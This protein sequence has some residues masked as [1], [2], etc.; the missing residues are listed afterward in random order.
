VKLQRRYTIRG[1]SPDPEV[2]PFAVMI[3]LYKTCRHCLGKVSEEWDLTNYEASSH[4]REH[5]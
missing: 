1:C 2:F 5:S 4:S 3:Y